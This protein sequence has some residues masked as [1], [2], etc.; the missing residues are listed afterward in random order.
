MSDTCLFCQDGFIPIEDVDA[1]GCGNFIMHLGWVRCGVCD[2][3]VT[4]AG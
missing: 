4:E 3:Y 1:D 2:K